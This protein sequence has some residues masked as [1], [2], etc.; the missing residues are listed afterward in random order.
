MPISLNYKFLLQASVLSALATSVINLAISRTLW[1]NYDLIPLWGPQCIASYLTTASMVFSFGITL[2]VTKAARK[3]LRTQQILPLHWHL[4]SQTIIDQLPVPTVHRAFILSILGALM[5]GLTI[6]LL[7][8][9]NFT[10]FYYYEFAAFSIVYFS[11][12][13]VAMAVMSAYR[14]MGDDVLKQFKV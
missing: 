7:N 5:A 3:A 2:I 12:L 9:K 10:A 4:K 14:A 1:Y 13:S 11:M 8:Y 6:F